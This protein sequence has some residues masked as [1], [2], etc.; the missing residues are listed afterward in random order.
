MLVEWLAA[1]PR[2][3]TVGVG[4]GVAA[5]IVVAAVFALG[6]RF[7]TDGPGAANAATGGTHTADGGS[8]SIGQRRRRGEIRRYLDR[9]GERYVEDARIGECPVA[10]HL[11]ER[12]V[13]ITFDPK[14]YVELTDAAAAGVSPDRAEELF[15]ILAEHEMPGHHLAHRLPF[16]TPDMAPDPRTASAPVRAAYETLGV[17]PDADTERVRDAYRDR[18][19]SVHP[20]QGGS[21]EAFAELQDAYATAMDHSEE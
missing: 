11:P 2:W 15:V 17:S 9:I 8:E 14:A 10:F 13:A 12:D 6:Q 18:V 4:L 3:L 21:R 19:K 16:E 7:A 5:A 20:D 1:L